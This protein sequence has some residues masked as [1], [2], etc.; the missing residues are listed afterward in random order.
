MLN[1]MNDHP[2][3][4]RRSGAAGRPA[5]QGAGDVAE[6]DAGIGRRVRELRRRFGLS[7]RELAR[8]A[9]LTNATISMVERGRISP[10]VGSLR[11]IVDCF[12]LPLSE[13]FSDKPF[14]VRPVFFPAGELT[15]LAGGPI[16]FRQVGRNLEGRALQVLHEVY[17]PGADTGPAPYHH[18]GEEA[19]VVVRGRIE[20]TVGAETRVLGPGDAYYFDSRT[21]HRFRNVGSEEC[22]IV[23]A[24]TPPGF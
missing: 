23:S 6:A 15:E 9:G 13:F 5:G 8:R 18:K 21:P 14:V 10:S 12:G 7:Q 1:L 11:K 22:E 19:G 16:S 4:G 24:C 20:V 17:R 3:E 2:Q